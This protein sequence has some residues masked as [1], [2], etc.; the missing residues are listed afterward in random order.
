M[1]HPSEIGAG[2]QPPVTARPPLAGG[3]NEAAKSA[4]ADFGE[5]EVFDMP[6][7]G[8]LVAVTPHKVIDQ[9]KPRT[10][11]LKTETTVSQRLKKLPVVSKRDT[12]IAHLFQ[13][14]CRQ[15]SISL[16]FQD[17]S[18]VRSLGFTS[19]LHGEGKTLLSVV[20]AN[21]LAN[22]SN[23]PVTLLDCNWEHPSVHEYYNVPSHPGLAEWIRK[24]CKAESILHQVS[25]NLTVV[26]A[27]NGKK[28]ALR[29]LSQI[30]QTGLKQMFSARNDLLIVDL[31]PI[32]TAAYGQIAASL[33]DTVVLVVHAGVTP[34]IVIEEACAKLKN[35]PVHGVILNQFQSHI[36]RWLRQML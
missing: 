27:G 11:Q 21:Q 31:P 10:D 7:V 24:E 8:R 9:N 4:G 3:E 13:E 30:R 29:L 25:R 14:R 5:Q 2:N 6:T 22:D 18:S 33:P 17:D 26:P 1:K 19:A 28:D 16:F 34:D 32:A 20:T 15:L 12:T 36:P 23:M 35:V